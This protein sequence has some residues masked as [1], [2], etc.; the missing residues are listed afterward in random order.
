MIRDN[1]DTDPFKNKLS[2]TPK[3]YVAKIAV[4]FQLN[5][6]DGMT[7]EEMIDQTIS[8]IEGTIRA[9]NGGK[10][11]KE[12]FK[13]YRKFV[14]EV[15]KLINEDY[16]KYSSDR[17]RIKKMNE[18]DLKFSPTELNKLSKM[19]VECI[20]GQ[21][22]ED[23]LMITCSSPGCGAN[24]H[25][26]CHPWETNDLQNFECPSCIILNNDPLNH[27]LQVLIEPSILISNFEYYFT[28]PNEDFETISNS[29]GTIG[30]EVRCIKLD[31]E[32]FFEQTWP[33]KGT[34]SINGIQIKEIRPLVLNSSL[35]KRKDERLVLGK[36]LMEGSNTLKL[37]Y[38][39][40][41]DDKNS[42]KDSKQFPNPKYVITVLL[43]K[44][45]SPN[46]L[47]RRV[48]SENSLSIEKAK[49]KV[50]EKFVL[51][52]DRE[53][54]MN[55]IKLDIIDNV[56]LTPIT[57]PA[58]GVF[59][60]HIQCF[61]LDTF[62]KSMVNENRRRWIC[63]VCKKRA[64]RFVVDLY[65][66]KEIKAA[67]KQD[68]SIEQ[69]LFMRDGTVKCVQSKSKKDIAGVAANNRRENSDSR[70]EKQSNKH[71]ADEKKPA[72]SSKL[73]QKLSEYEV[74]SITS[75]ENE[76]DNNQADYEIEPFLEP[77]SIYEPIVPERLTSQ[78]Y[79]QMESDSP[80]RSQS[81]IPEP[82]KN[83]PNQ[84]PLRKEVEP[85]RQREKNQEKE[86]TLNPPITSTNETSSKEKQAARPTTQ[87]LDPFTHLRMIEDTKFIQTIHDHINRYKP[88][89]KN[90]SNYTE[91]YESTLRS[92]RDGKYLSK[93]IDILYKYVRDRRELN[94]SAERQDRSTINSKRLSAEPDHVLETVASDP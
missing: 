87:K 34:L 58:R 52:R 90:P 5:V 48:M 56:S 72:L 69:I 38:E 31:G 3:D 74:F 25:H 68:R 6:V 4:E 28:I 32:H 20:C 70:F 47:I 73:P 59:C 79:G 14:G 63:P 39:N 26:E 10:S 30:V 82:T 19:K 61:S 43:I 66:E 33:D 89:P 7:K 8:I 29:K 9:K 13:T 17:D 57:V 60:D 42:K 64:P 78:E 84:S 35:K 93:Y 77:K 24:F 27:I 53:I 16:L 80:S 75:Q 65:L 55:E 81:I 83:N 23:W 18:E 51:G 41:F 54:E 86:E 88:D 22:N 1:L 67:L 15:V 71:Y 49:M 50:E 91:Y 12:I 11:E 2:M 37:V 21:K 40:V 46:E 94:E 76:D 62:I 44:R 36:E 85:E 45:I 92:S